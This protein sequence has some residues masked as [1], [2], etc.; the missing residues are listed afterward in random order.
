MER[1]VQKVIKIFLSNGYPFQIIKRAISKTKH[2]G[3]RDRRKR[4][5][6]NKEITFISLPF[7]DDELTRKINATVRS[8]ELPIKIAWQSGQTVSDVLVR[9][10]LNPPR[11][12][13]GNK[14]CHACGAGLQGQC[15]TKNVVYEISVHNARTVTT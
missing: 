7:I 15:T 14:T 4:Q 3:K 8:S 2:T 1:S 6:L 13:S 5:K 12:P 10:A 11:C 9:S